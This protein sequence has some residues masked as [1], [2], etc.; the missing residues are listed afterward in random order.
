MPT[1]ISSFMF[2]STAE[3][4]QSEEESGNMLLLAVAIVY[5]A[6]FPV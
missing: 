1:G 3:R 5:L 4:Y 2:S 6:S